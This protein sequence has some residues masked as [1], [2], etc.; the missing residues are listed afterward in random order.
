MTAPV[1]PDRPPRPPATTATTV[2]VLFGIAAI[3]LAAAAGGAFWLP[4]D[5]EVDRSSALVRGLVGAAIGLTVVTVALAVT[6]GRRRAWR[7]SALAAIAATVVAFAVLVG[8]ATAERT[9]E[10]EEPPELDLPD[11]PPPDLR[12]GAADGLS[13]DATASL[14]DADGDGRPDRDDD[15]NVII[16]I[17]RDGDG[18]YDG[19]LVPC[20]ED[21]AG[22]PE[23][24]GRVPLDL[25]CDGTVEML[26]TISPGM[27]SEL[28]PGVEL[29]GGGRPEQLDDDQR[30]GGAEPEVSEV[31]GDDGSGGGGARA[32]LITLLIV[33][34]LAVAAFMIVTLLRRRD[35]RLEPPPATQP[36]PPP[37]APAVDTEAVD[38]AL[39]S[40]IETL[41]GHPDP[42]LAIRAA[43]AVLLDALAEAGFGRLAFEAP[44]E[45]LTR[46]LQ[47]L[48]VEP[49]PLREL[50]RLFAV[51][52]FSTH[53]VTETERNAALAAL[54]ASQDELRRQAAAQGGAHE[55]V[56]WGPPGTG[57]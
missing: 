42:R 38:A 30:A 40:S 11:V 37:D 53:E 16:A 50:L 20:R 25:D 56:G 35:R 29:P 3:A 19:R 23:S 15:G 52:R 47:G 14:V 51:A 5:G 28:P 43:Y 22:R 57:R 54:R 8:I 41:L 18:E 1:S 17:D 21:D 45:H 27:L 46:C 36:L 44:E 34:G 33:A 7:R 55:P 24:D 39:E 2:I 26:L 32:V 48:A 49:A 6:R 4:G 31:S 13:E 9:D 12:P 10:A